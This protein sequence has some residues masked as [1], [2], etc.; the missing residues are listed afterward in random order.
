MNNY[1]RKNDEVINFLNK[2]VEALR[3][4]VIQNNTETKFIREN[5]TNIQK[6]VKEIYSSINGN[7]KKGIK[8]RVASLESTRNIIQGLFKWLGGGGVVVSILGGV[9]FWIKNLFKG[10]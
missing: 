6:D 7:G 8:E 1:V 4:L 3:S 2:N 5:I 10:N 9:F